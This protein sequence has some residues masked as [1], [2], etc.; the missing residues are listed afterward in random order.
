MWDLKFALKSL[1]KSLGITLINVLGFS[2]GLSAI[3]FLVQYLTNEYSFDDFHKNKGQI[4][5]IAIKSY[6]N[7]Q[8]EDETFV[9]TSEVGK[10]IKSDFPEVDEYVSLTTPSNDVFYLDN[11]PHKINDYIYAGASFFDVFSFQ[12]KEG[13]PD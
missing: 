10:A 1:K 4:Y 7:G 3:F 11:A 8:F 13:D 5:R 12:L 2:L 6:E 9:Y